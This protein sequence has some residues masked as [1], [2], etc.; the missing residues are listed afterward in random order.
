MIDESER[1]SDGTWIAADGY[2][3]IES[4]NRRHGEAGNCLHLGR[5]DRCAGGEPLLGPFPKLNLRGIDWVIVGGESGPGAR[6]MREE[7]VIDLRDQ[8]IRQGVA[9]FFKQSSG[10]RT[11]MGTELIEE[12]GTR[13]LWRQFPAERHLPLLARA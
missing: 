9:F 13:T 2:L 7:W 12:D 8:C 3:P 11:E 6:P 5:L 10:P 1:V 4:D